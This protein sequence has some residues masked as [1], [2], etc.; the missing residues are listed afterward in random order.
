MLIK[1]N[2]TEES[3]WWNK[4]DFDD[5]EKVSFVYKIECDTRTGKRITKSWFKVFTFG[6]YETTGNKKNYNTLR[7]KCQNSRLVEN[8]FK[9]ISYYS[10]AG[11]VYFYGKN[12]FS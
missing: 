1:D 12:I 8:K 3:S 7:K 6:Q 11:V 2:H 9:N 5:F 10:R 4:K